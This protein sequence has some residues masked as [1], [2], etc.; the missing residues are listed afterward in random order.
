MNLNKNIDETSPST[1]DILFSNSKQIFSNF[2]HKLL[3]SKDIFET[4]LTD[5]TDKVNFSNS[6]TTNMNL[7]MSRN[8]NINSLTNKSSNSK[9]K[10]SFIQLLLITNYYEFSLNNAIDRFSFDF[11]KLKQIE[12]TNNKFNA[13]LENYQNLFEKVIDLIDQLKEMKSMQNSP[14][15]KGILSQNTAIYNINHTNS[16]SN[17]LSFRKQIRNLKGSRNARRTNSKFQLIQEY[18]ENEIISPRGQNKTNS[19]FN[20]FIN[21]MKCI[22]SESIKYNEEDK[23]TVSKERKDILQK[24]LNTSNDSKSSINGEEQSINEK[25]GEGYGDVPERIFKNNRKFENLFF[26]ATTDETNLNRTIKMKVDNNNLDK[27]IDV[28]PT[29]NHYLQCK[30]YDCLSEVKSLKSELELYKYYSNK[31]EEQIKLNEKVK[32]KNDRII[33]EHLTSSN[34]LYKIQC[35]N[36]NNCIE[37]IKV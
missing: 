28:Y 10:T 29:F 11:K 6:F 13:Q 16:T 31:Q 7:N 4:E 30:Q 33:S 15:N 1:Y 14:T 34:K 27:P 9:L 19:V 3:I 37:I 12:E 21:N 26:N 18:L 24:R 8:N 20:C 5:K 25:E 32:S 2:L 36:F 22:N 17:V 23:Y 35:V